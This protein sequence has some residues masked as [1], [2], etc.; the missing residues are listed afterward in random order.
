MRNTRRTTLT[1][2]GIAAVALTPA[3]AF[4][5]AAVADEAGDAPAGSISSSDDTGT[6]AEPEEP[7]DD[8]NGGDLPE[9]G[10][11]GSLP[12]DVSLEDIASSLAE[13][14]WERIATVLAN[15]TAG[16]VSPSTVLDII[17]LANGGD[18]TVGDVIGSVAG[19]LGVE[20]G[21]SDAFGSAVSD[22]TGS[23]FGS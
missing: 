23:S 13:A 10:T 20:D 15:L 19:S 7:G 4:A 8:E 11:E 3:L 2:V 22:V 6:P 12:E 1:R 9:D 5:P 18:Q 17:D 21:S 14:D 16:N